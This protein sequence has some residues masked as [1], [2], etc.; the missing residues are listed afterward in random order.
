MEYLGVD[1]GLD[2]AL[3]ILSD[4]GVVTYLR[5]HPVFEGV[6]KGG[7]ARSYDH[8]GIANLLRFVSPEAY[9]LVELQTP[10]PSTEGRKM[11]AGSAF[12]QGGGYFLWLQAFADHGIRYEI[13]PPASWQSEFGISRRAGDTKAQAAAVCARLFPAVDVRAS[14]R[15]TTAHTGMTDALLIAEYA[16]RVYNSREEVQR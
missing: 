11:P 12:S 5:P 14:A 2:G 4:A 8:A 9:A 7:K 15:C 10:M 3:A 16:R 1:P 13:V 6:R